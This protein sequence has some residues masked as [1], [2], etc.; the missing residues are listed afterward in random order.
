LALLTPFF[1]AKEREEAGCQHCLFFSGTESCDNI[2]LW[3]AVR[4]WTTSVNDCWTPIEQSEQSAAQQDRHDLRSQDQ[5]A[6]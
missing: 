3:I 4:R 2:I 6:L 5:Q 1:A